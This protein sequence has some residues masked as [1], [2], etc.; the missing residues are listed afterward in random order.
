MDI[1]HSSSSNN[2]DLELNKKFIET[3][4]NE[5][6]KLLFKIVQSIDNLKELQADVINKIDEI[7]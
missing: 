1:R 5:Q 6:I 7:N 3:L 2:E 4:S